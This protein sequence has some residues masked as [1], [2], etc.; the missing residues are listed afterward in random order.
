MYVQ[1]AQCGEDVQHQITGT[2][3]AH[4]SAIAKPFINDVL[5]CFN[6]WYHLKFFPRNCER[7]AQHQPPKY[8]GYMQGCIY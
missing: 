5:M 4:D 6:L 7:K 1:C 2:G 8:L 3:H